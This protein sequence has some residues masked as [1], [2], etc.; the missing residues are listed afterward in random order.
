LS[1][2]LQRKP[3]ELLPDA[4]HHLLLRP[5]SGDLRLGRGS[6]RVNPLSKGRI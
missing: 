3:V 5:S 6:D 1:R 4:L 2:L